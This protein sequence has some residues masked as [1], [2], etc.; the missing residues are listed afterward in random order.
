MLN[1]TKEQLIDAPALLLPSA[2]CG[3]ACAIAT[4]P[5]KV[6]EAALVMPGPGVVPRKLPMDA[7]SPEAGVNLCAGRLAACRQVGGMAQSRLQ[8][9]SPARCSD[10]HGSV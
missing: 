9:G 1:L 5:D 4:E 2:S 8:T 3:N 10:P 6:R 7:A